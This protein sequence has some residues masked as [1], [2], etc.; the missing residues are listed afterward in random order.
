MVFPDPQTYDFPEWAISGGY[1]LYAADVVDFGVP[2]T[3]DNVE[4]AYKKGIFPWYMED[5]PLPWYCPQKRAILVFDEMHIP[6]SLAKER[7]RTKFSFS[8]DKDFGAVIEKCSAVARPGQDGTWITDDFINVYT[9]LHKKGMVHSVETWNEQGEL[10]GGMYGVD[11]GGVFCGESMFFTEPNASK[12]AL[13]HL[14]DHL[15]SRGSTWM[16]I[17]VMT[18]HMEAL[19]AKEISRNTFLK[20]LNDVQQKKSTLFR[21]D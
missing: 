2:L 5:I 1:Y 13:L 12:L 8:I 11:A 16:D 17:Q 9:E 10:V 21:T 3:A 14:I 19:G 15:R 20:A 18:P 7:R 6:R 4:E